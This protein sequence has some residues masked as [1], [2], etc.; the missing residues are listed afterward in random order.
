VAYPIVFKREALRDLS[1][2]PRNAQLRFLFAFGALGQTPTRPSPQL[3]VKQM[4][5]RPGFWRLAV[6]QWR[7]VY[8]FDGQVVRFYI[9][10][11]R[12]TL[13]QQFESRL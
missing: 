13:Y 3:L 4:R 8:S 12:S 7:G 6:G 10:G 2:L 5:D 11:D 1:R 9:F